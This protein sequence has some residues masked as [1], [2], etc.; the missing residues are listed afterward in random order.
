MLLQMRAFG[1]E[2]FRGTVR[3][4]VLRGVRVERERDGR[5]LELV[6][7]RDELVEALAVVRAEERGARHPIT[8]SFASAL[9][10]SSAAESPLSRM[11]FRSCLGAC[12]EGRCRTG[13]ISA[14]PRSA[15]LH[16]FCGLFLAWRICMSAGRRGWLSD[17]ST[18]TT[19]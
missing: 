2:D 9:A 14:A 19:Q 11:P 4:E 3:D 17:S 13:L 8:P 16:T 7:L 15:A 5:E 12:I 1:H 18:V 10:S 6:R